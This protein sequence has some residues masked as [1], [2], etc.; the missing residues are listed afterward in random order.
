MPRELASELDSVANRTI[1][2]NV[3]P[4][5]T[6]YTRM[7]KRYKESQEKIFVFFHH[8]DSTYRLLATEPV[9]IQ[10]GNCWCE[11]SVTVPPVKWLN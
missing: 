5:G 11:S 4:Q 6:R 1:S 2:Q 3:T 9:K 8:I 7:A 10:K